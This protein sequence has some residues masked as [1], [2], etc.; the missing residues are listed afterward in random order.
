ML[1]TFP[2]LISRDVIILPHSCKACSLFRRISPRFALALVVLR[3]MAMTSCRGYSIAILAAFY[4]KP[5]GDVRLRVLL[6]L[7]LAS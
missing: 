3:G 4:L 2:A 1:T 7:R 6:R 5:D